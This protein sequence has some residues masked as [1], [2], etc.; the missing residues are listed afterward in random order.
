[1]AN[2][3]NKQNN[4]KNKNKAKGKRFPKAK[5]AKASAA[6][7]LGSLSHCAQK[8]YAAIARPFSQEAIGAC[9]PVFP[10]RASQKVM[11]TMNTT[12]T[13]GD[14]GFGFVA[15]APCL[16][17]GSGS[18]YT[19]NETHD[20]KS[21]DIDATSLGTTVDSSAMSQTPYSV[22][23]LT[24]DTASS[25][26]AIRGRII[27]TAMRIRYIGT[28]LNL[29][30]RMAGYTSPSHDNLNGSDFSQIASRPESVRLPVT[31]E[32]T[33]FVVFA[34]SP[35]ETDYPQRLDDDATVAV[36]QQVYP[37]SDAKTL[38]GGSDRGGVPMAVC[39]ESTAGNKFEVEV[40]NHMEY[41]GYETSSMK[42]PSHCDLDGMSKVQNAANGSF[43]QRAADS[44][45][46]LATSMGKTLL[47]E[48][49]H[50]KS[51]EMRRR[52]SM[53]MN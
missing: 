8:Y 28:Q 41:I 18:I 5:K 14:N 15:V 47:R 43:F 44:T 42:T 30:G 19:T 39:I 52:H 9:M 12:M 37:L 24:G 20:V 32:W 16:S 50:F 51:R 26:A 23:D 35:E 13:I 22:L 49:L 6:M 29:G 11:S 45:Y 40:R 4:N 33:E 7:A 46:D 25:D 34:D 3:K 48:Y 36:I 1:M 38:Y 17:V 27:S 2:K 53:I 31:R 10:S 21:I